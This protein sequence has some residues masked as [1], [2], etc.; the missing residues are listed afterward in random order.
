MVYTIT[1]MVAGAVAVH[2]TGTVAALQVPNAVPLYRTL[3]ATDARIGGAL[4]GLAGLSTLALAATA[5]SKQAQTA[6]KVASLAYEAVAGFVFSIALAFSGMLQPSKVR[7]SVCSVV[8]IR[9]DYSSNA[10]LFG[11]AHRMI[12]SNTIHNA[13]YGTYVV[14][15]T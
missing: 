8:N 7:G 10:L 1:F 4:L 2:M 9:Y 3:S 6:A 15:H 12:C 5:R 13:L 11:S 14:S